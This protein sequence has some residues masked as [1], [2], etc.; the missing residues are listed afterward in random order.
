MLEIKHLK[1]TFNSGTVN[2]KVAMNGINLKL[3]KGDFVTIIGSNGAGKS[4]LFNLIRV[5]FY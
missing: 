2:E 1:K 3:D 4:T 5:R